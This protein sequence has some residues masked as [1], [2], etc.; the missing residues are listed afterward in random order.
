METVK[1]LQTGLASR[2]QALAMS[3]TNIHMHSTYEIFQGLADRKHR[4]FSPS[5]SLLSVASR[6]RLEGLSCSERFVPLRCS[7]PWWPSLTRGLSHL[8]RICH[9]VFATDP[10]VLLVL[11]LFVLLFFLSFAFHK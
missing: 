3:L 4:S 7:R 2:A 1:C 8:V 10:G 6:L 11:V 5:A 9:G